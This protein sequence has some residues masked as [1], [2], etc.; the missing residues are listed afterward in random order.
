MPIHLI[1]F[2]KLYYSVAIPLQSALLSD[3]ADLEKLCLFPEN[4][5]IINCLIASLLAVLFLFFSF[6]TGLESYS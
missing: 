1:S 5:Y 6:L 2:F 3:A 4:C